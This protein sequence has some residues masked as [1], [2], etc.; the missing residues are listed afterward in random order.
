MCVVFSYTLLI[1]LLLLLITVLICELYY[2]IIYIY[3]VLY[4]VADCLSTVLL[5]TN[6]YHHGLI[7]LLMSYYSLFSW[8]TIFLVRIVCPLYRIMLYLGSYMVQKKL[9]PRSDSVRSIS[10]YSPKFISSDRQ[11]GFGSL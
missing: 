8:C 9:G 5:S 1:V 6:Y 10:F 3:R 11:S 2:Y 7:F 4:I